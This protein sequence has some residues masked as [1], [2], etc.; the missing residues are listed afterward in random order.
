MAAASPETAGRLA[1]RRDPDIGVAEHLLV[2]GQCDAPYLSRAIALP[3]NC[4]MLRHH[5]DP[6]DTTRG[7][8]DTTRGCADTMMVS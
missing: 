1:A 4:P 5:R 6:C 2:Y 7:G 8:M 3:S